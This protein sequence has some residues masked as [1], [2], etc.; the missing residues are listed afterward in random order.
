[1]AIIEE[2][3]KENYASRERVWKNRIITNTVIMSKMSSSG[4]HH[5]FNN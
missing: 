3:K 5:K 1:M 4:W 2:E